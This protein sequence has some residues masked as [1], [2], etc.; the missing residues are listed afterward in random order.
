M[1]S[2]I[3]PTKWQVYNVN[4]PNWCFK[5]AGGGTN[6]RLGTAAI[7]VEGMYFP[8]K[9]TIGECLANVNSAYADAS[10]LY[11]QFDWTTYMASWFLHISSLNAFDTGIR[12]GNIDQDVLDTSMNGN[13]QMNVNCWGDFLVNAAGA[14]GLTPHWRYE[15]D[16]TYFDATNEEP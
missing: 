7:Y 10:D 8:R 15:A 3:P 12:R 5:L 4:Y 1:N 6:S 13:I 2:T 16:H 11:I 9:S 14:F